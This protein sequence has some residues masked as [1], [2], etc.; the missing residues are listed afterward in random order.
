VLL[1]ELFQCTTDILGIGLLVLLNSYEVQ[2]IGSPILFHLLADVVYTLKGI[3]WRETPKN[4]L[5]GSYKELVA[6]SAKAVTKVCKI[7]LHILKITWK[8]L[9]QSICKERQTF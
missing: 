2:S 3:I 9:F 4:T 7:W 1:L 5:G 6:K 8:L